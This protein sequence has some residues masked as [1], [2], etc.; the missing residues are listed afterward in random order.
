MK[1]LS[2][3]LVAGQRKNIYALANFLH[4]METTAP[5]DIEFLNEG[6]VYGIAQGV[7]FGLKA[8]PDGGFTEL[9]FT[10]ASNQ[11]IK[12]FVGV[13]D[14]SNDRMTGAVAILNQQGAHT[15]TQKSVTNASQLLLAANATR[16]GGLIQNNDAAAVLR[17]TVDGVAASTTRGI[18]IQ[19]GQFYE[20]PSYAASG[21]IY[22][23]ME[24]ATGTANNVEVVEG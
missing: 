3:Y 24:T 8:R 23:C 12:I 19:S 18:R 21:A 5:V 15:Q 9:G 11:T 2:I 4:L 22:G 16:R 17:V 13:G 20:M 1:T 10:S 6:A 14:G 7:E